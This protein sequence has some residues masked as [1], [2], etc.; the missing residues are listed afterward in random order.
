MF[1]L[2]HLIVILMTNRSRLTS[3]IFTFSILPIFVFSQ[4]LSVL[5]VDSI[6]KYRSELAINT[7]NQKKAAQGHYPETIPKSLGIQYVKLKDD[8]EFILS[9]S[10]GF[11]VTQKFD[12]ST[13]HWKTYG[14]ND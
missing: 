1:T 14:W 7:L 8:D 9:Y 6:Q 2:I 4:F 3:V 11:M 13:N 12:S 10:K 5:L